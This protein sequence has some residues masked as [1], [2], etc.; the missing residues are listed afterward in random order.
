[1]KLIICIFYNN[2][3]DKFIENISFQKNIEFIIINNNNTKKNITCSNHKFNI[4]NFNKTQNLT[5][6]KWNTIT[7]LKKNI[8]NYDPEDV[9]LY[10]ND[11][12]ELLKNN[13]LNK[14]LKLYEKKNC[15]CTKGLSSF[16]LKLLLS[17]NIRKLN[18]DEDEPIF[19]SCYKLTPTNKIDFFN[20]NIIIDNNNNISI[21]IINKKNINIDNLIEKVNN[22]YT[23]NKI[24]VYNTDLINKSENPMVNYHICDL[25]NLF[26]KYFTYIVENYDDIDSFTLFLNTDEN[27]LDTNFNVTED[28]NFFNNK[29]KQ[30]IDINSIVIGDGYEIIKDVEE[31]TANF[32]YIYN[33]DNPFR[34]ICNLLQI[35]PTKNIIEWKKYSSFIISKKLIQNNNIDIYKNIVSFLNINNSKKIEIFFIKKLLYYIFKQI[36]Y[37]NLNECYCD[38]LINNQTVKVYCSLKRNI[39][40]KKIN[41]N[42]KLIEKSNSYLIF[43]N[44][45]ILENLE[46]EDSENIKILTL[47]DEYLNLIK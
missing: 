23:I 33:T 20:N 31:Y 30:F 43:E 3:F 34:Y 27:I 29:N 41:E 15:H 21:V 40:Y 9:I 13:T 35:K 2:F 5:T 39:Y 1:M 32:K 8:K 46:L 7:F 19:N 12:N 26:E 42:T 28:I 18:I 36:S 22:Y 16:K 24:T 4:V 37:N 6:C 10:I 47:H 44:N 11:N 25:N 14:L 17:I 38:Y 45:K